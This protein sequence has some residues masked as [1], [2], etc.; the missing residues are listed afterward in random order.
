M[1]KKIIL[2]VLAVV[3]VGFG[4]AVFIA[5]PKAPTIQN[6]LPAGFNPLSATYTIEGQPVTLVNG[7]AESVAAPGSATKVT[8][9]IF[10]EPVRGDLTGRGKEDAVVVL[11]QNPGG[12]GIFYY[13]AAALNVNNK[14]QGTNAVL[15][16]DRIAPQTIE[17]KNGQVIANYADRK[18][19]EPMTT[20]PSV[21]VSAHL[22]YNGSLLQKTAPIAGAGERCGGNMTTAP[23]CGAGYHCA[24]EPG[25]HLPFGDVGG[26]CV[27]DN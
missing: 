27:K 15:L 25:S 21:G 16:G 12:S 2:G 4:V 20:S 5:G 9:M 22:T 7:R 3:V 17:I 8:T 26:V 10:G 11:V 18:S 13:V 14:A 24:P 6:L 19:G 1:T 23:T